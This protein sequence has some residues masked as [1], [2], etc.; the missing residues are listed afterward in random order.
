MGVLLGE[1]T[2]LKLK[3]SLVRLVFEWEKIENSSQAVLTMLVL[4]QSVLS[5]VKI[6]GMAT[7]PA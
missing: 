4:F 3:L 2:Y 1:G 7:L 6:T 5:L